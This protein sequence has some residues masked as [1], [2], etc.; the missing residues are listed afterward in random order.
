MINHHYL[1]R[2]NKLIE[3]RR[4][5]PLTNSEYC[6]RHHIIPKCMGGSD[7]QN[8]LVRLSGREHYIAHYLLAKAYPKDK[9]LWYSF[10]M[11]RRISNDKSVLYEAARKYISINTSEDKDRASKISSK[12]KG[13]EK[14]SEHRAKLSEARKKYTGWHHSDETKR[15]MSENGLKG[16]RMY[17]N[18]IDQ[19]TIFLKSDEDVPEGYV[20]GGNEKF[21]NIGKSFKDRCWYH[22]P[23]SKKNVR[24]YKDNEPPEGYIKGRYVQKV[25]CCGKMWDPGNLKQHQKRV[26][27]EE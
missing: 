11:M 8:N 2:Y 1:N 4:H 7:E 9:G 13:V 14:S 17:H 21:K 5:H 16:R 19:D 23:I 20:L 24:V 3:Y 6:E 15:K 25:E 18:P 10:N 26:H 22:H 12:L 27:N